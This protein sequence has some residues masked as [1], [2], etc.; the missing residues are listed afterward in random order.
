MWV[1]TNEVKTPLKDQRTTPFRFRA[2]VKENRRRAQIRKRI[3]YTSIGVHSGVFSTHENNAYEYS[4]VSTSSC[5]RTTAATRCMLPRD[6]DS[7]VK[8]VRVRHQGVLLM[9][10]NSPTR[11]TRQNALFK[12]GGARGE[13]FSRASETQKRELHLHARVCSSL[14]LLAFTIKPQRF[15]VALYTSRLKL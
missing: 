7:E 13:S 4:H 5:A 12:K 9:S 2:K 3:L 10:L 1:S 11:K 6:S 14:S 15:E 8:D